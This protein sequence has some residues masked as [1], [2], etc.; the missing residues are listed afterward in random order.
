MLSLQ[1]QWFFY[2]TGRARASG[3]KTHL[4]HTVLSGTTYILVLGR[5]Q[6]SICSSCSHLILVGPGFLFHHLHP[7]KLK[8]DLFQGS[9][10]GNFR[11]YFTKTDKYP[12]RIG[13][14]VVFVLSFP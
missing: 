11:N 7:F 9:L 4:V 5:I 2:C 6:L 10:Q 14:P 12:E 8:Y 13:S 1:L 3:G